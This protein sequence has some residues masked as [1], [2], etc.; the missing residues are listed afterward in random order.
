[1]IPGNNAMAA[2]AATTTGVVSKVAASQE[3][4]RRIDR[5]R[6]YIYCTMMMWWMM[7]PSPI[8]WRCMLL[9]MFALA[10]QNG[11]VTIWRRDAMTFRLFSTAFRILS[12][13]SISRFFFF[14]YVVVVFVNVSRALF[15]VIAF[16]F[17][18][19]WLIGFSFFLSQRKSSSST[20]PSKPRRGPIWKPRSNQVSPLIAPF[21]LIRSWP[22]F[23]VEAI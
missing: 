4:S 2:A 22:K 1:M 10:F 12:L 3:P 23:F 11:V 9:D 18:A 15:F 6:I 8:A 21:H 14:F 13:H 7:D 19:C 17:V 5:R 20:K 16:S